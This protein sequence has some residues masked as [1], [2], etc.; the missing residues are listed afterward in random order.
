VGKV[1]MEEEGADPVEGRDLHSVGVKGGAAEVEET[2]IVE[3]AG[4]EVVEAVA[5]A[6]VVVE[7]AAEQTQVPLVPGRD[8]C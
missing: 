6:E 1:R 4:V 5:G 8:S 2:G 7:A 3:V